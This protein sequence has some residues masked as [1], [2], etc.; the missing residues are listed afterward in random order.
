MKVGEAEWV[1]FAAPLI[2]WLEK[3]PNVAL[4]EKMGRA[5]ER[6]DKKEYE[7]LSRLYTE[8]L[9]PAWRF[10]RAFALDPAYPK[11]QALTNRGLF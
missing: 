4:E 7:R 2:L 11:R 6:G 8:R 9:A 1:I 10:R 5:L 3:D